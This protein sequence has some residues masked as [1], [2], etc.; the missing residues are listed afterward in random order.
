MEVKTAETCGAEY[1]KKRSTE[2]CPEIQEGLRIIKM[3][4]E[5]KGRENNMR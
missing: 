1:G 2:I 4:K 5:S 3:L